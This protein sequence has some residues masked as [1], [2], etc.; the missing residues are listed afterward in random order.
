[1]ICAKS[2]EP[3]LAI[4]IALLFFRNAWAADEP[5]VISGSS[6]APQ[7]ETVELRVKLRQHREASAL[8]RFTFPGNVLQGTGDAVEHWIVMFCPG[9]HEKCQNLLPSY[10]LLGVQ[11]EDKLNTALM[12]S[13][14]RFAKVDCATEKGLCAS[15]EVE[16]YPNVVHYHHQQRVNAWS[17]GAPGLVR[18]IKDEIQPSKRRTAHKRLTPARQPA[19]EEA[20]QSAVEQ[21]ESHV[22]E[23]RAPTTCHS[24]AA[25]AETKNMDGWIWQSWQPLSFIL[26][27]AI[28]FHHVF[29]DGRYAA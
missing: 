6:I 16:D 24:E 13:K 26:A 15:L 28:A 8:N 19:V 12:T 5:L 18:W 27:L 21:A 10:E 22:N 3:A 7:T 4:V 25:V 14:V 29:L 1:M 9:W 11:W 23:R 2:V 17:G 20:V